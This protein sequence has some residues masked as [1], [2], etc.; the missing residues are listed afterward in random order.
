MSEKTVRVTN[1]FGADECNVSCRL[2]RIHPDGAFY[3]PEDVAEQLVND[4]RSGFVRAPDHRAPVGSVSL[5]Q[6]ESLI[7]G[8]DEGRAKALL[9]QALDAIAE[10][11]AI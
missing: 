7:H 1:A 3:V 11:D 5:A 4:G 10:L 2:Y 8:L 6:V 9:M